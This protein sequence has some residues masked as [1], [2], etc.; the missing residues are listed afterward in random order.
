MQFLVGFTFAVLHL[1]VVYTVPV[2]VPYKAAET[3]TSA[4]SSLVN[5]VTDSA[6]AATATGASLAILKKLVYRAAG[7]EGLAENVPLGNNAY[8]AQSAVGQAD[9]VPKDA[10]SKTV[11][12]TEYQAVPCIDTSGEAFAVYLNAIYLAPLT[13]LFVRFFVK[14]YLRRTSPATKRVTKNNVLVKSG[15]DAVH[16]IN[17]ELDTLGKAPEDLEPVVANGAAPRGGV[18]SGNAN[19]HAN[20]GA[21]GVT[22]RNRKAAAKA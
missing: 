10:G 21:N 4:A 5:A 16:G 9:A 2:S 22:T 19:G 7:E 8:A 3:I 13:F 18:T 6:A 14:S 15:A 17:K 12:R 1:F 20:G 11:Y